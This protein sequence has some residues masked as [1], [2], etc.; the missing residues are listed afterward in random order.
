EPIGEATT[1]YF[2]EFDLTGELLDKEALFIH[3]D[4]VDYE[5]D[6]FMNG[7]YLGSHEGFF[8]PFE[9]DFT[10]VAK[11]GTNKLLVKVTNHE[12]GSKGEKI[13]AATGPGYDEPNLGWHHCPAGMG[14]YQSVFIEA[15]S[16][17]HVND[18]FIRPITEKDSAELW[19]EINNTSFKNENIEIEYSIYGQN[20]K[21]ITCENTTYKPSTIVVPGLGDLA[22]ASDGKFIQLPMQHGAN[23]L[24]IPVSIPNARKWNTENPWL[25]QL[26]IKVKNEAGE[27]TDVAR[28]HFGMRSFS[29]DTASIPKGR[30]Y[31][32]NNMVR[33]RGA[34]T[35]GH[36]QG[37]VM[38]EDWNQLRDDILLAKI[39]NMNFLRMTQRPVQSEI[40]DYCDMLGIMTQTDLPLFGFLR[41]TKF[42]E[43]VKQAE[44]MERLIRSHPCNILVSYVNE[45]F[46]N[47]GGSPHRCFSD[48]VDYERF[49]IAAS[50]SVLIANPDRVIKPGDGDYDPPSPGL[51]DSHCYNMWY[52]GH[53]LGVG[54]M[55]KGF[56]QPIKPEWY[57]GCG[58]YGSEGLDPINVMEKYYPKEWVKESADGFWQPNN[59]YKCQT[60]A[61][62]I[63]WYDDQETKEEWVKASQEHQA[64]TTK[65]MTE[66][67]RRDSRNVSSAI[68]LFIDAWPGGW[69]KTIMDVDRQ[70]KKAYFAYRDAL[71]PLMVSLRTD[72]NKFYPNESAN[73]EVWVCNDKNDSPNRVRLTY[74]VEQENRILFSGE[75]EIE[76]PVNSSKFQ[77]FIDWKTPGVSKRTS[78]TVRC[79]IINSNQQKLHENELDVEVF[80]SQKKVPVRAFIIGNE[81][82]D[83][84]GS[85]LG[86]ITESEYKN[87]SVILLDGN[88]FSDSIMSEIEP[89]VKEGKKLVI[90]NLPVGNHSLAGSNIEVIPTFMGQYYFVSTKTGHPLIKG[91]KPGDFKFWYDEERDLISPLLSSMISANDWDSVLKTG[92][93]K[94]RNNLGSVDFKHAVAE[95]K[96]GKG[97]VIISHV[98][99][100][101][102]L[103]DN[104]TALEFLTRII[105]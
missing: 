45:R 103:S 43:A 36:L 100:R 29:M 98:D 24:K 88:R 57:Y 51:P 9:F 102:K 1:Y 52:N 6:V 55:Y 21:E 66:A 68:H 16:Q 13:Y 72:R 74:Q 95:K 30:L 31:L 15:R 38:R 18:L 69:M 3:F 11:Q 84:I 42:S 28:Q 4:G 23:F 47:A 35:M 20:F 25:Y 78:F 14:I 37:C 33:L 39:S 87:A 19:I 76:V 60:P 2:R 104:P 77:G 83:K 58:E 94:R 79:A 34:N 65:W 54:E 62:Y 56:W 85:S 82:S 53:G 90:F 5:A 96:L 48:Y 49:Y 99:F 63:M 32:N 7:Y 17:L 81:I 91:F 97:S 101:N 73:I 8:A 26:Q 92:I 70:P 89:F 71:T 67:F 61:F 12:V 93:G 50:Q 40:Y 44:E 27:V 10:K 105:E 86:L 41:R 64:L 75:K 80:P 46:P 59:I 22:K